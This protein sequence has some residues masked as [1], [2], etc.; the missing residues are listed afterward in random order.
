MTVTE[1][2]AMI[3]GISGVSIDAGQAVPYINELL[4]KLGKNADSFGETYYPPGIDSAGATV[5]VASGSTTLDTYYDLPSD[6]IDAYDVYDVTSAT[7]TYVYYETT[8]K[9][10]R[11]F[12]IGQYKLK[13]NKLPTLC[14]NGASIPDCPAMMHL[15]FVYYILYRIAKDPTDEESLAWLAESNAAISNFLGSKMIP[16]R[17]KRSIKRVM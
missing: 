16:T 11:F 4:F 8:P 15:A 5:S 17:V 3:Q 12:D 13:Y 10:I 1:I 2:V 9:Q 7:T 6:F 14:T